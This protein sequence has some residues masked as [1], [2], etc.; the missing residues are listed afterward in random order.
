MAKNKT[1]ISIE[2][3]FPEAASCFYCGRFDSRP[4]NFHSVLKRDGFIMASPSYDLKQTLLLKPSQDLLN[5]INN[6]VMGGMGIE[7]ISFIKQGNTNR[8]LIQLSMMTPNCD[9][10]FMH[11][12]YVGYITKDE[13]NKLN[14][15]M[16]DSRDFKQSLSGA[17]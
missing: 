3:L 7:Y 17:L 4:T 14:K 2:T 8:V 1:T 9:I 13:Y 15:V 16:S 12:L 5:S 11:D 10:K 6:G